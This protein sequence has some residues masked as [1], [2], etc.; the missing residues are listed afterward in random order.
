MNITVSCQVQKCQYQ[1]AEQSYVRCPKFIFQILNFQYYVVAKLQSKD[2]FNKCFDLRPPSFL[3]LDYKKLQDNEDSVLNN[4]LKS[5][6]YIKNEKNMLYGK[7]RSKTH[8]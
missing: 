5:I 2:S 8:K 4:Y 6:K 1:S 3:L 7:E